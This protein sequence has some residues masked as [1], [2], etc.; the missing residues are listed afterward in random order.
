[1][2]LCQKFLVRAGDALSVSVYVSLDL[3]PL[4]CRSARHVNEWQ[5]LPIEEIL[6]NR[7]TIWNSSNQDS[8]QE[9]E[10]LYNYP[11]TDDEGRE[12]PIY[13]TEGHRIPRREPVDV[14][15]PCGLLVDLTKIGQLFNGAVL[16]ENENDANE[17][18]E[19]P[20]RDKVKLNL[21][22]A[23]FLRTA[24][25]MQGNRAT[26]AYERL[27]VDA[28]N[29][30]FNCYRH[31]RPV[32]QVGSMQIYNEAMHRIRAQAQYHEAQL[33][34]FTQVLAGSHAFEQSTRK[35][36]KDLFEK[37]QK[38]SPQQAFRE[39]IETPAMPK[40]LRVEVVFHLRIQKLPD[41]Q[42]NGR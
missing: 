2:E 25:H 9:V 42:R 20:P 12:I 4:T 33:G 8:R 10:D 7:E 5:D 27:T 31:L 23:A 22:P 41:A 13:S 16:D 40:D 3:T 29:R 6:E 15:D 34:Y 32:L 38:R 36:A 18:F 1:M 11:L 39:K 37:V 28:I 26:S 14:D 21:Y 17:D 35:K 24:G 19:I 30:L